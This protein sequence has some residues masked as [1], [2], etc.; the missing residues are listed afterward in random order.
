VA[1]TWCLV[2]NWLDHRREVKNQPEPEGVIPRYVFPA[3]KVILPPLVVLLGLSAFI[4]SYG[5]HLGQSIENFMQT[6]QIA[7]LQTW[8]A[9][10]VGI[11]AVGIIRYFL[12]RGGKEALL[13][14]ASRPDWRISNFRLLEMIVGV[15]ATLVLLWLPHGPLIPK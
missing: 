10:L 15:F 2:G 3:L 11:P 5:V 1:G 7:L 14:S 12:E 9:F 6:I 8:A 13:G 4:S